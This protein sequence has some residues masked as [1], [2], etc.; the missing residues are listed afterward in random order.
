[1]PY[2]RSDLPAFVAFTAISAISLATNN[3]N[4]ELEFINWDDHLT[5][6]QK[7]INLQSARDGLN[8]IIKE[9]MAWANSELAWINN[10]DFM[11]TPEYHAMYSEAS[12]FY[13]SPELA[14]AKE[15]VNSLKDAIINKHSHGIVNN[16]SYVKTSGGINKLDESGSP[17]LQMVKSQFPDAWKQPESRW[18]SIYSLK[19]PL[20][21]GN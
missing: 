4:G 13:N 12:T 11:A 21:N 20:N 17:I 15:A 3:V 18:K 2:V 10:G 14:Q 16:N 5:D 9:N 1:M 6:H 19:L 8:S 7:L